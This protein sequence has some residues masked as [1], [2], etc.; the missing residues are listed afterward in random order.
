MYSCLQAGALARHS[1]SSVVHRQTLLEYL[2]HME[3]LPV[4]KQNYTAKPVLNSDHNFRTFAC[5]ENCRLSHHHAHAPAA[6][7]TSIRRQLTER[8]LKVLHA[9]ERK[10][11]F[12]CRL[13]YKTDA[14]NLLPAGDGRTDFVRQGPAPP[15][16][17]RFLSFLVMLTQRPAAHI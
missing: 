4:K 14:Q 5:H 10:A 15:S 1:S 6:T 2:K 3:L 13:I 8:M 9:M 17:S 12:G 7:S 16:T 11:C